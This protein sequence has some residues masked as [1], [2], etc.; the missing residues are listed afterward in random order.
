M[1]S[2]WEEGRGKFLVP[3]LWY[4]ATNVCTLLKEYRLGETI[5]LHHLP[6]KD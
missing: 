1:G 5:I 3:F 6:G 4:N 2:L